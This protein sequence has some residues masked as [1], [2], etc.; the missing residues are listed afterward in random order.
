MSGNRWLQQLQDNPGHSEWYIER[1]A[2]MAADGHD[3]HGEARFIDA[4]APRQAAI[5]DAG[6]G[7]GRIGGHLA[8]LGHTV[9]GV[10]LDPVLVAAA[11]RQFPGSVWLVGDLSELDLAAGLPDTI[12]QAPVFDVIFSAGNVMAFLDPATRREVLSRLGGHLAPEGRAV[13]AFGAGRDYDFE[14]FFADVEAAGLDVE[15]RLSTWDLRPFT[16]ASDFLVAVLVPGSGN[17]LS[18]LH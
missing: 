14:E 7:T 11:R 3:L 4:M 1:F 17:D 18:V 2:K 5:L 13:I 9:V 10:D 6:S 16:E 15:L 8:S 12:E